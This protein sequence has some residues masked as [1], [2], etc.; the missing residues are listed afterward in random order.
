[1]ES[2]S[3]VAQEVHE[4]GDKWGVGWGGTD[5]HGLLKLNVTLNILYNKVHTREF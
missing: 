5:K 4:P 1:M 3:G 2:V